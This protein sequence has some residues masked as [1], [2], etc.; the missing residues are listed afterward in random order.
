MI[1]GRFKYDP[2]LR[3]TVNGKA[4]MTF[5]IIVNAGIDP[6]QPEFPCVVWQSLA[7]SIAEDD[8][9][10]Q[11]REAEYSVAGYWKD[12]EWVN[13]QTGEKERIREY[14]VQKIWAPNDKSVTYSA[15]FKRGLFR[16]DEASS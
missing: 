12:R 6:A 4:V 10:F 8:R 11:D 5:T 13:Q 15:G 16:M 9:F 7:V 2:E 14:I 3:F 1:T